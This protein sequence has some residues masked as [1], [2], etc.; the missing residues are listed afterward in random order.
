MTV[1]TS[2][3]ADNPTRWTL[4]TRVPDD[5]VDLSGSVSVEESLGVIRAAFDDVGVEVAAQDIE[6]LRGGIEAWHDI[7]RRQN[8]VIHGFVYQGAEYEG[9]TATGTE[10]FWDVIGTVT[11]IKQFDGPLSTQEVLRHVLPAKMGF[12][13]DEAYTELFET[14]VGPAIGMTTEYEMPVE[15]PGA[16]AGA[17]PTTRTVGLATVVA[18]PA[19]GGPSLVLAGWS[20][21]PAQRNTLGMLLARIAGPATITPLPA[22]GPPTN[23][24]SAPP[25]EA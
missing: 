14:G 22:S 10:V 3:E 8:L 6:L 1:L 2:A 23:G 4:S 12:E 13:P 16:P 20:L 24:A 21:D 18:V 19:N 17:E 25:S 5:W 9:P 15:V 11:E 7:S